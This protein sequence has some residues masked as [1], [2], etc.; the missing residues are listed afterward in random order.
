MRWTSKM[1]FCR[2]LAATHSNSS[3]AEETAHPRTDI[4]AEPLDVAIDVRRD[5]HRRIIHE[6]LQIHRVTRE[7]HLV[8]GVRIKKRRIGT[9]PPLEREVV[10]DARVDDDGV[11]SRIL[12]T[13]AESTMR[14]EHA[15]GRFETAAPLFPTNHWNPRVLGERRV[16][17]TLNG[18]VNEVRIVPRG[19]ETVPTE[20]GLVPATR[21]AYTGDL[22]NEIWYDDVGR[23]VK[24]RFAAKG[25][26]V[27]DYEC[28]KCGLSASSGS[29]D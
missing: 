24:M 27:I 11:Q 10:V 19:R 22:D 17:N 15:G 13:R 14:I 6:R 28:I 5:V 8:D 25:G 29:T 12:A 16:L 4:I 21:Y 26:S 3:V 23:W 18:Y 20:R 1:C 2:S 9:Q 7:A